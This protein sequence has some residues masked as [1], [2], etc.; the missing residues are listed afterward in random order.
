MFVEMSWI[1][2]SQHHSKANPY[3]KRC[4]GLNPEFAL[5]RVV[6]VV[7]YATSLCSLDTRTEVA[8]LLNENPDL[9]PKQVSTMTPFNDDEELNLFF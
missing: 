8:T 7:N 3:L 6:R 2:L 4:L 9:T 1:A 5:W